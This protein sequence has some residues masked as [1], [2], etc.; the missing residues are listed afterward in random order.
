MIE[1]LRS[2]A[3]PRALAGTSLSEPPK[4]PIALRTGSA[5]TT[6]DVMANLLRATAKIGVCIT[7]QL[8]AY[9]RFVKWSKS[10]NVEPL[11]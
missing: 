10:K 7:N 11:T 3:E 2:A 8:C 5:K 9:T 4:V 6:C 1:V